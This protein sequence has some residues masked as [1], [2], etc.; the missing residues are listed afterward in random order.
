MQEGLAWQDALRKYGP[1][2]MIAHYHAINSNFSK[3]D[4]LL[5]IPYYERVLNPEGLYQN[6]GYSSK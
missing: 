4:L 3:K 5:P 1:E 2:E 6:P